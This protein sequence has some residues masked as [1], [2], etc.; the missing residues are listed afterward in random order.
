[1]TPTAMVALVLVSGVYTGAGALLVVRRVRLSGW[2][3]VLTGGCLALDA[4]TVAVSPAATRAA[5]V[6]AVTFAA[7]AVLT[8]PAGLAGRAAAGVA[9]LLIVGGLLGALGPEWIGD[10]VL[11]ASLLAVL[12]HLWWRL[13]RTAVSERTP[14]VW[15][16]VG[17]ITMVLVWFLASFP[18]QGE[19]TGEVLGWLSPAALALGMGAG[20]RTP[21]R[22]DARGLVVATVVTGASVLSLVALYSIGISLIGLAGGQTADTGIQ[23]LVAAAV[24]P[25]YPWIRVRMHEA[26]DHVLF[27]SRPDPLAAAAAVTGD[28]AD[29]VSAVLTNLREQLVLPY[30]A[31]VPADSTGTPRAVSGSA[32]PH[33][34]TYPLADTAWTLEVGLRPGDLTMPDNDDR[35]LRLVLPLIALTLRSEDLALAVRRSQTVTRTAVEDERRRLRRDLHDGLGPQ[36]S[37]IA[38][39]ADAARNVLVSDPDHAGQLLTQIR[40]TATEAL[41]DIRRLVYAMRP[42]ALD[43]LGLVEAIRRHAESLT[44]PLRS[45]SVAATAVPESLPAAVE[46]AALRITGEAVTN[47]VRH[48]SGPV[49]VALS[50]TGDELT[51]TVTDTGAEGSATPAVVTPWRPGVGLS[52]MSERAREIGGTVSWH[53]SPTGSQVT[54]QLPLDPDL[55]AVVGSAHEMPSR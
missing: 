31:V 21:P 15:L 4:V 27:G 32:T 55:T 17:L 18:L 29:D 30:V 54:A 53:S 5:V 52:A 12:V 19:G 48:G 51:V 26:V 42:P 9:I 23:A 22:W 45:I 7:L 2:L 14:L 13:E 10:P 41:A 38:F 44:T 37:G 24:A 35:V 28:W 50:V 46:V 3:L 39:T 20:S 36:L 49:A 43:E 6:L 34:R 11:I 33:R 47:A 16:V 25:A 8:F 1:M 40:A